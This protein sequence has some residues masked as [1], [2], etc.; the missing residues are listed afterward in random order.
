MKTNK[1]LI[2][3]KYQIKNL[4]N[5]EVRDFKSHT[6]KKYYNSMKKYLI[7]IV[8]ILCSCTKNSYIEQHKPIKSIQLLNIIEDIE[9]DIP[10]Q[11]INEHCIKDSNMFIYI[12]FHRL[13]DKKRLSIFTTAEIP[14]FQEDIEN[15]DNTK[16]GEKIKGHFYLSNGRKVVIYDSDSI[17]KLFYDESHL[18]KDSLSYYKHSFDRNVCFE[19]VSVNH[20]GYKIE[21]TNLVLKEKHFNTSI[22]EY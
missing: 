11:L 3:N 6:T 14:F 18:R 22:K 4:N 12:A 19:S 16:D 9:K 2:L 17:G 5:K 7:I 21:D 13:D 1:K 8:L 20:R 15:L 10:S